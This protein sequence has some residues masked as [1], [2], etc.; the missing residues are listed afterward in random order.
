[1]FFFQKWYEYFLKS[2]SKSVKSPVLYVNYTVQRNFP[3][4]F[5]VSSLTET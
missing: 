3:I 5:F 4:W 2:L 1:M